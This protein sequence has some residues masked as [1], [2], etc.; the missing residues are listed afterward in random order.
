VVIPA[1]NEEPSIPRT[2]RAVAEF[3][4]LR[5]APYEIIV[6]D[7]GSTDG[8]A[9]AARGSHQAVRV[10]TNATNKGKGFSVRE[11]MLAARGDLILFTDVDLA[12]PLS[13]FSRILEKL[14]HGWDVAIATRRHPESRI[15]VPQPWTRT[16]SGVLF[17]AAVRIAVLKD[18]RD[19]QCGLKGFTKDA[20]KAV[21]RQLSVFGWCFDVEALVAARQMGYRI[22]EVPVDWFDSGTSK[23]R[24]VGTLREIVRDLPR[25][26][27]R[28]RRG[29]YRRAG[30]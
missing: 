12:V 26:R 15:V 20:A 13:F 18:F 19:T 7:D 3:F 28:Q 25:I 4:D 17:N 29:A 16:L 14:E 2:V 22:V 23:V 24:P 6:V 5:Q 30:T 8:T 27:G 21:F 1:L 9:K 11:G 10:I